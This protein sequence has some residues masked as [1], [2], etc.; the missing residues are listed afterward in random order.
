MNLLPF[1]CQKPHSLVTRQSDMLLLDSLAVLAQPRWV[2]IAVSS[3]CKEGAS[4]P[5]LGRW[6]KSS[7]T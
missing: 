5:S 6:G 2:P 3:H 7:P 4:S 1:S